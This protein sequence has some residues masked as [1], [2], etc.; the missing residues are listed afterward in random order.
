MK[1]SPWPMPGRATL[2]VLTPMTRKLAQG[3]FTPSVGFARSDVRF[4]A[5]HRSC[6]LNCFCE[7]YCFESVEI[8]FVRPVR[9]LW[10]GC[11]ARSVPNRA[12]PPDA[13]RKSRECLRCFL[14]LGPLLLHCV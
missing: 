10:R 1:Q 8:Y 6:I 7:G 2:S 12:T 9:K 14:S 13:E 5:K 4:I 11:S 3:P